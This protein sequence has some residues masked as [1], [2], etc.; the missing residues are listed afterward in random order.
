M[1]SN[2]RALWE[3]VPGWKEFCDTPET[4]EEKKYLDA[5][6][7]RLE[8][9]QVFIETIMA[10]PTKAKEIIAMTDKQEQEKAILLLLATNNQ[11]G[12]DMLKYIS[13]QDVVMLIRQ[14]L[15]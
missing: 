7:R 1:D 3:S 15:G 10:N 9:K 8:R 14:L 11:I 2:E 13:A 6:E 12:K 5:E 4:A